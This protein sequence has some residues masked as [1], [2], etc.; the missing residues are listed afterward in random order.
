[1]GECGCP[2]TYSPTKTT[3]INNFRTLGINQTTELKKKNACP[4]EM[5]DISH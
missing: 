1:M 3:K 4:K 2:R 5:T